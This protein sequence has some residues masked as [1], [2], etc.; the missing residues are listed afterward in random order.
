MK[1][2]I[3]P[4][5]K[6]PPKTPDWSRQAASKQA[7]LEAGG[8]RLCVNLP[9]ASLADIDKITDRK[10]IST[11]TEAIVA[12]LHHFARFKPSRQPKAAP[13]PAIRQRQES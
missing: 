3:I 11:N 5:P 2:F 13:K 12:A 10:G 6:P 7:L 4:T 9:A 1:P 8:K